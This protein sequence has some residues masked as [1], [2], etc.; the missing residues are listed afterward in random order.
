MKG[1]NLALLVLREIIH[2]R[3]NFFLGLLSVACATACLMT[4]VFLL[5]LYDRRTEDL[6]ATKQADLVQ[7]TKAMEAEFRD[8]TTRMGFNILVLPK[9]QNLGD[10]YAENYADKTMPEAYAKKLADEPNI[11]TVRHLLPMLQAKMTW[12]EQKR[13]ILLI[14]VKGEMPWAHR[15]NKKPIL[16]PVEP[17]TVA[18]GHE[19][20]QSL[21]LKAGDT[22][23]LMGTAFEVADLHPEQGTIGDITLWIDLG[24]AQQLLEKP[25]QISL[26]QALECACAWADL[27]RVRK[28]IQGFLPDTQV[29]ELRSKALGRA[30][31]R[32]EATRMTEVLLDS[33]KKAQLALK[34]E[35]EK[36]SAI[37]VPLVLV[38]CALLIVILAYLNVRERRTEI[39]ILRA[40]GLHTAQIFQVFLG[41]ALLLGLLG[42]GVGILGAMVLAA[43]CLRGTVE[44]YSL[45][46]TL[47]PAL[48]VT[49]A[50]VTPLVTALSSWLPALMAA[51][52]D[53]AL[54][55]REE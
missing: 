14:G 20:H 53:P 26:I 19:L 22:L 34:K 42:A 55:L 3:L 9:D 36:L 37:L 13:K 33:E 39:G 17:G 38:A 4:A 18:V 27:P 16:R 40:L 2:R 51:Q 48:I 32:Q 15:D 7:Q 5:N 11:V 54:V 21:A 43:V 45:P 10:F 49:V 24:Q 25:G 44:S 29:I 46:D 8:I 30:E 35:R 31:A 52:Q 12:P 23:T 1:M 6:I 41:K 47:P 50:L 28:E